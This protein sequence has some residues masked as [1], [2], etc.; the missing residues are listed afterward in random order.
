MPLLLA[1]P[2]RA[3]PSLRRPRP[4]M[5]ASAAPRSP[6]PLCFRS[7]ASADGSRAAYFRAP[8]TVSPEDG[9]RGAGSALPGRG[10]LEAAFGASLAGVRLHD[11]PD[12]RAA[13]E[14]LGAEAYALGDDVAVRGGAPDHVIAHEAAHVLQQR[15][16]GGR[17]MDE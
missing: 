11:G 4:R 12:A 15:G 1:H 8:S 7:P 14:A 3:P 13:C 17:A 5:E 16:G 2:D 9:V 10:R 6:S